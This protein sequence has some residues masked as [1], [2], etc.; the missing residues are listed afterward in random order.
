MTTSPSWI[1]AS[2]SRL[3]KGSSNGPPPASPGRAPE[4]AGV[5]PGEFSNGESG[6]DHSGSDK[7]LGS[8]F[9]RMAT[10]LAGLHVGAFWDPNDPALISLPGPAWLDGR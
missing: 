3:R 7:R 1:T 2:P 4:K 10:R 9:A 8:R 6:E 5:T